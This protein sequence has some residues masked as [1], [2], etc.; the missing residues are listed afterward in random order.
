MGKVTEKAEKGK[1]IFCAIDLHQRSMLAGVAIGRGELSFREL[2]SDESS[3]VVELIGWLHGLER[4]TGGRVWVT[5]EASGSGFRLADALGDEGFE[6]SV[7]APTRLPVSAK[8]RTSKTDKRDVIRLHEVLRGHVL[9]GNELPSV[10]IPPAELRD[11]RE[12]VRRRLDLKDQQTRVKNQIH[13]LLRRYGLKRP[14]EI[15][16]NWTQKYLRWLDQVAGDLGAG[17][18]QLLRS[19]LREFSFFESETAELDRA[20]R[21][22]AETERYRDQARALTQIVGVGTLSAMVFLTELGD[23]ERFPNRRALANYTGLT[24]RTYESGEDDDHKGHIS[25]QGPARVRKIL[26]QAAW[27][28]VRC[29]GRQR[30]WFQTRKSRGKS[31]K[32]LITAE[33]RRLAIYMWHVALDAKLGVAVGF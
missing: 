18:G 28:V 33:M 32:K 15:K 14:A 3:G 4:K 6:V 24:P 21:E 1:E 17:A 25:K 13:G 20:V 30:E 9:A 26:N 10:W 2:D 11:D 8:S 22:L 23:L 12:I 19:L 31:S 7:L 5:Y 16:T 27:S 29:N